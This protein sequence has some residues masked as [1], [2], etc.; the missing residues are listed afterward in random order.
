[1]R[2]NQSN[3]PINTRNPSNDHNVLNGPRVLNLKRKVT[4]LDK[5]VNKRESFYNILG[6]SL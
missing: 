1:M 6:G 2:S 5:V 4:G 3:N